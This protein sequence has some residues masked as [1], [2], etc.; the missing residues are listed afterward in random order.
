[1]GED[2]GSV[3]IQSIKSSST[4][5]GGTVTTAA[6]PQT[7]TSQAQFNNLLSTLK[8]NG[9]IAG[10]QVISSSVTSNGGDPNE[11]SASSS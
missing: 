5:V 8:S 9:E 2:Y 1:M 10:M 3:S 6:A 11:Q 7:S 4:L